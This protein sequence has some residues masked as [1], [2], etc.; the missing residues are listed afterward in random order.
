SISHV[1]FS[2]G[3]LQPV[4]RM[5]R[6]SRERGIVS[7]IDG[8]HPP[9]LLALDL[10]TIDADYYC[11]SPHKWLLSPKGTGLLVVRPDRIAT[12]WP[13]IASGNGPDPPTARFDHLGTIT[14]SLLAGLAAAVAFHAAIGREGGEARVRRLGTQL[15]DA[16][17]GLPTIDVVTPR[18]PAMRIGMVAFRSSRESAE[19]L[20]GRLARARVR[21]RRIAEH[22]L[23]Y[24]RLSAH[25]YTMPRDLER[26]VGLVAEGG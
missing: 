19:A 16:L 4:A 3:M 7:V 14:E 1:L 25:V 5:V 12:T 13:L 24:L 9:G 15:H 18:A 2:T 22:G 6:V 20:Q 21:T 11:A 23:E 8:A 10:K 17:R 26:V